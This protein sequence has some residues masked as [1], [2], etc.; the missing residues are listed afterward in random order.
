MSLAIDE[1]RLKSII[2]TF[3]RKREGILRVMHSR[4]AGSFCNQDLGTCTVS[5]SADL[6]SGAIYIHIYYY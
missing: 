2:Y 4:Y 3:D 5:S 1:N 6:P